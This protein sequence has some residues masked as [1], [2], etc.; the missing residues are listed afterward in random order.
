M[1]VRFGQL[2]SVTP[3]NSDDGSY[4]A[5][6]HTER[7]FEFRDITADYVL[8]EA[9]EDQ[10]LPEEF[11]TQITDGLEV[12]NITLLKVDGGSF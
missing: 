11:T 5:Y 9:S 6:N 8:E 7:K 4:V 12:E 1:A 3:R 2:F 10:E